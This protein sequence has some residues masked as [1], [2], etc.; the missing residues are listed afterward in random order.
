MTTQEEQAA[1]ED[2]RTHVRERYGRAAARF[3]VEPTGCCGET[4]PTEAQQES[5]NCC[6]D[7]TT[8]EQID[9][10][11][12]IYETP[13]AADLPEEVTGLSMGCGDPITLAKLK[14]GQTVLDLG[15]GG[16]IDCFL[17][18]RNVGPSGHVI[19][20]DMT[21]QMIEKARANKIKVGAENVEFRLGEI[22]HLPVAD[23]T[24]DVIIS[25]CVINLSPD[26]PQVFREAYRA[27][28]PGGYMAVSD[29]VT[30]G[31][32]PAVIKKSISAWAGCIAG[33][34]DVNDYIDAIEAA[35]FSDVKLT[36]VYFD[37]SMVD[38]AAAQLGLDIPKDG[39]RR[40]IINADTDPEVIEIDED[41]DLDGGSLKKAIFSAKITAY[42]PV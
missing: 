10:L 1:P 22:E 7:S 28:K 18:G 32:L 29:I 30:D 3:Q 17:A 41:I 40:F 33:A 23:D 2:I 27:L 31:P 39:K 38:D 5:S 21:A 26:K 11:S 35:G 20:V 4:S 34:M 12:R 36:P 6:G 37:D 24:V 8:P 14:P 19:G 9:H 15:S 42:K 25:N 13:D 16:G